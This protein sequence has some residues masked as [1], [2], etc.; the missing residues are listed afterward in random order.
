M[1]FAP[2]TYLMFHGLYTEDGELLRGSEGQAKGHETVIPAPAI[3]A[4]KN[5]C[6][7]IGRP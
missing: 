1:K 7:Q 5:C 3:A 4:P 2:Y 6:G